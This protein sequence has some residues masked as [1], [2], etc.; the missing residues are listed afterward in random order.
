MTDIRDTVTPGIRVRTR[1]GQGLLTAMLV[2]C[3]LVAI[4]SAF[5][6]DPFPAAAVTL[7]ASFG[8]LAAVI[9][10]AAVWGGMRS[11]TVR[12]ALWALPLFFAWHVAVLG[13]WIPDAAFAVVSGVGILLLDGRRGRR[14]PG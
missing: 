14:V 4:S 13:T 7:I 5:A 10:I 6:D 11:R 12:V 2:I 3:G 8:S 1:V 9:G